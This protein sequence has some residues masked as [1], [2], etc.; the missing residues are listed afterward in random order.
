MELVFC[1]DAAD[2]TSQDAEGMGNEAS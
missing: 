2:I 1:P